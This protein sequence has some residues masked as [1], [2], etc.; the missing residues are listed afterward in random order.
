MLSG[1]QRRVH[2][3]LAPRV[4]GFVVFSSQ[5]VERL[6][7]MGVPRE[8]IEVSIQSADLEPVRAVAA[9]RRA[10]RDDG[11]VRVLVGRAARARQE[12]GRPRGGVRRG[13]L[14][15]GR[16]GA[17]AVRTGP[18]DVEL[19]ALAR[20]ARRAAAAARLRRARRAA[21]RSTARPTCSRW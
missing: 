16:G 7:R 5:G 11:P 9:E 15:G 10:A 19:S 18:L 1:L 17:R 13:G 8:R 20:A 4:D 2:R 3:L 6:E 21:R 14:R 12:P